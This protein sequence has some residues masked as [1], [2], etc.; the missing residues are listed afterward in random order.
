D[1]ASVAS[2]RYSSQLGSV[3]EA[4]AVLVQPHDALLLADLGLLLALAL[5]PGWLLDRAVPRLR[6]LTVV[7]LFACGL[8]LVALSAKKSPRLAAQYVGNTQIAG[9]LGLLPYQA[10]DAFAYARRLGRRLLPGG[11]SP[12]EPAPP[13]R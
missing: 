12:P 1:L 11:S 5:L 10:Y 4:V 9:D 8:G 13:P 2:L 3:E 7:A 6:P